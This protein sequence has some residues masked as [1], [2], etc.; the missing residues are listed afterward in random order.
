MSQHP[1]GFEI[2]GSTASTSFARKPATYID[3]CIVSGQPLLLIK[4]NR[5]MC[6]IV[7]ITGVEDIE[8]YL[9]ACQ[10]EKPE[11]VS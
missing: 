4:R 9:R 10:L 11:V 7:P 2:P 5:I 1:N 8:K 3:Q 6:A